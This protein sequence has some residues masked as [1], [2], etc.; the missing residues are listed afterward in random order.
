LR[1]CARLGVFVSFVAFVIFVLPDR[2]LAFL[3]SLAVKLTEPPLARSL[4]AR[5]LVGFVWFVDKKLNPRARG[6]ELNFAR[7]Q[8]CAA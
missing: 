1:R 7:L 4:G 2:A 3:A 5:P 6:D 8:E